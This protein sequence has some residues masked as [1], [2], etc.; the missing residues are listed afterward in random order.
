LLRRNSTVRPVR[1]VTFEGACLTVVSVWEAVA[2]TTGAVPTW[3]SLVRPLPARVKVPLLVG[4]TVWL[5][6]HMQE[7]P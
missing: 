4:V 2:L 7:V 1:R 3:T 5:W 6:W